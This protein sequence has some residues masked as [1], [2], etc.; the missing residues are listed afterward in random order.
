[1]RVNT[2][3]STARI[4]GILYIIGTAAG[5]TSL[6]VMG[7]FANAPDLLN[8]VNSNPHRVELGALLML[9]MGLP[10]AMVAVMMFPILKRQNEALAIGYVVFRGALEQIFYFGTA[11]CWL[12]LVIVGR[13][14]A[15]SG[16]T[17]SSHFRVL[18]NLVIKAVDP[19]QAIGSIVF[20]LGALILY[21]LFFQSTLIPRWISVF[22]FVCVVGYIAA[23]ISA[24]FGTAQDVL[25]MPM[26][27][28]E[29]IMAV[30]LIVKGFNPSTIASANYRDSLVG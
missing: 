8:L 30:W 3:R 13:Q 24:L 23:G 16:S 6:F 10:L 27:L 11:I 26:L 15:D 20:S 19:I 29:M 5:V 25:M 12:V 18:G 14:Y 28:Q 17:D 9:V 2:D 7:P 1:M 4:V 22:G 21:Y